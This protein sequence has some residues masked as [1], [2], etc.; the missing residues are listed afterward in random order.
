MK[1]FLVLFLINTIIPVFASCPIEGGET[2]CS[3]P[4]FREQVGPVLKEDSSATFNQPNLQL[5]PLNREDPIDQMRHPNNS[6][7]YNSHCQF[8]VCLQDSKEPI[9]MQK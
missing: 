6:L 2:V 1:K 9:L 5:Q 7:N 8:G 4:E 3:L